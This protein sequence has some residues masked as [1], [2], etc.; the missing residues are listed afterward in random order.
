MSYGN[1]CRP[2][3]LLLLV[4]MISLLSAC[5]F[6][7]DPKQL[8][9][10]E[11]LDTS[12]YFLTSQVPSAYSRRLDR[13]GVDEVA[14]R[15]VQIKSGVTTVFRDGR[16]RRMP[17]SASSSCGLVIS[18]GSGSETMPQLEFSFSTESTSARENSALVEKSPLSSAPERFTRE[19]VNTRNHSFFVHALPMWT[20]IK[21]GEPELLYWQAAIPLQYR[22][23]HREF[24]ASIKEFQFSSEFEIAQY[25]GDREGS[26]FWVVTIEPTD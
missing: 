1:V 7:D 9:V 18:S 15:F 6:V 12:A 11:E 16:Q 17:T 3:F 13:T 14:V 10:A 21:Q 23:Q 5:R 4:A 2:D 25:S 26:L 20:T 22:R 19:I 24:P 8:I